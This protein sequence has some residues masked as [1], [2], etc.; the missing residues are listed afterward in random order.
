MDIFKTK[1]SIFLT[2]II[3]VLGVKYIQ[4]VKANQAP[5]PASFSQGA[6]YGDVYAQA[7]HNFDTSQLEAMAQ[8]EAR[9]MVY[10][11][12]IND[13]EQQLMQS[14]LLSR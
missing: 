4:K 3:G 14:G 8:T 11:G 10:T 2:I 13:Y 9:K 7:Q 12:D 6:S 5:Q 1:L